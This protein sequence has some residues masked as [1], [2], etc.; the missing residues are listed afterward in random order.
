MGDS[1]RN[2]TTVDVRL[3][4]A[5]KLL[6][7]VSK[8]AYIITPRREFARKRFRSECKGGRQLKGLRDGYIGY[9][10]REGRTFFGPL[11][12]MPMRRGAWEEFHACY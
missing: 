5:S 2:C 3:L 6:V 12:S 7:S 9:A 1:E 10:C 11:Y 4:L 8:A